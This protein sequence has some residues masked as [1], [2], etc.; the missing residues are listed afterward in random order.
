M[1]AARIRIVARF[2]APGSALPPWVLGSLAAHVALVAALVLMPSLRPH[3]PR[4]AEDAIAV[5][6]VAGPPG[7]ASAAAPQAPP[8]PPAEPAAPTEGTKLAPQP[9]P[10]KPK[11]PP[12]KVEPKKPEPKKPEPKKPPKAKPTAPAKGEGQAKPD[13]ATPPAAT[14]GQGKAGTAGVGS[15][16]EVAALQGIDA[17]FAWYRDSV[18]AALYGNWSRPLVEGLT[19]PVEVRVVFEIERSGQVRGLRVDLSSGVQVLDRSAMRAVQDAAPLPPLP[20]GFSDPT[21]TAA[22]VFRLLPE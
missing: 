19:A 14:P 17:A 7:P 16:A 6:L 13:A 3:R 20:R 1:A 15:G 10:E 5:K 22:F 11:P 21:L 9:V 2:G 12:P 4:I 18:T 8:P